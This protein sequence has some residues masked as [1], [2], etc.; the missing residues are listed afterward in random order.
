MAMDAAHDM[1]VPSQV[2]SAA[3]D[4]RIGTLHQQVQRR[5]VEA[6]EAVALLVGTRNKIA[7][8]AVLAQ[9]SSGGA[10][11]P[12]GANDLARMQGK[13]HVTQRQAAAEREEMARRRRQQEAQLQQ[14]VLDKER[15][16]HRLAMAT[17]QRA[18]AMQEAAEL[19]REAAASRQL[20]AAAGQRVERLQR[21]LRIVEDVKQDE[22]ASVARMAVQELEAA[23]SRRRAVEEAL[24]ASRTEM[25]RENQLRVQ[26][27]QRAAAAERAAAAADG[28]HIE[29]EHVRQRL[30][31]QQQAVEADAR[32]SQQHHDRLTA[33]VAHLRQVAAATED[34]WRRAVGDLR[35]TQDRH[36]VLLQ[37]HET[38]SHQLEE[39]LHH[40]TAAAEQTLATGQ[41]LRTVRHKAAA[42][43]P[44]IDWSGMAATPSI[45]AS[46]AGSNGHDDVHEAMLSQGI[47][48]EFV[49]AALPGSTP[50]DF[51]NS[52][53]PIDVT[54][55]TA[56]G[57]ASATYLPAISKPDPT[58]FDG[59]EGQAA[60]QQFKRAGAAA[61]DAELHAI[62]TSTEAQAQ[63]ERLRTQYATDVE[64][65]RKQHQAQIELL[66][67]TA[68]RDRERY[69]TELQEAGH[70]TR[71][72]QQSMRKGL[73]AAAHQI[74]QV[75]DSGAA[76]VAE[77]TERMQLDHHKQMQEQAD[78]HQRDTAALRERL[79]QSKRDNE[80]MN[81]TIQ[82]T[83][84]RMQSETQQAIAVAIAAQ[85]AAT[86]V[87]Q[88][89]SRERQM[90]TESAE[91]QV[92]ATIQSEEAK[93]EGRLAEERRV[94]NA[95]HEKQIEALNRKLKVQEEELLQTQTK[96]QV[97][98]L[99]RTGD[100]EAASL[101][102]AR[103]Q[104]ELGSSRQQVSSLVAHAVA[105][106]QVGA[107][108]GGAL[109]SPPRRLKSAVL[110]VA[111]LEA[112]LRDTQSN[113]YASEEKRVQLEA[114]R[115][116]S[117]NNLTSSQ[118]E[119]LA[120]KNSLEFLKNS[121][122]TRL[123]A[124]R[125]KAQQTIDRISS[126][127]QIERRRALLMQQRQIGSDAKIAELTTARLGEE[128]DDAP[129]AGYAPAAGDEAKGS[130]PAA[131]DE[132]K[133]ADP[134]AGEAKG[135]NPA[136]GDGA[137]G[138]DPASTDEA[139]GLDAGHAAAAGDETKGSA[140]SDEAKGPSQITGIS[141]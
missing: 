43:W 86:Q 71:N 132:A 42:A 140:A 102:I 131:G 6:D 41:E 69:E 45:S 36:D 68:K 62:R 78:A 95:D 23:E 73:D 103:L 34:K 109:G 55:V 38:L 4:A 84:H 141:V 72:A 114:Q 121:L 118:R 12:A 88:G 5:R 82:G 87:A 56:P 107:S 28:T 83:V 18:T 61:R 22:I 128:S 60:H 21:Q 48:P 52:E 2:Q 53:Q 54:I 116:L 94:L 108:A 100:V 97:Q 136:A 120:T 137:K 19:K 51:N 8:M 101:E 106:S 104:R 59:G 119:L 49:S 123:A 91:A 57:V 133:S 76:A 126:T 25:Q 33:T 138:S 58:A 125:A 112:A 40:G 79:R 66:T 35:A 50:H 63:T 111:D 7:H 122:E 37:H 130:N 47:S 92:A 127:L 39:Q 30:D 129:A 64:Q 80:T 26:A 99:Q 1:H 16:A 17:S 27:E 115:R 32:V 65:L 93:I 29:L 31:R 44:T 85:E 75:A 96:A 81:D 70:I 90:L 3:R 20:E 134:A 98:L 15:L 9:Q 105:P 139:K 113:F 67:A 124:E 46:A 13:L 24:T 10:S 77:Q 135:S 14:L 110:R 117:Q 89:A 11:N 74:D